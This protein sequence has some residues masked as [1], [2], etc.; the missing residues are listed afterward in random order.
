[1]F[2]ALRLPK[3]QGSWTLDSRVAHGIS[4]LDHDP[5]QPPGGERGF[6]SVTGCNPLESKWPLC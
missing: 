2:K 6:L 4:V 1:M 5:W 3:C